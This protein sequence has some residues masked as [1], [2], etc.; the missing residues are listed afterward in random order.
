[1][2]PAARDSNPAV[3]ARGLTKLFGATPAL[4][5]ADL[6]VPT[7]TVCV[8]VGPNGAGK[9]TLLRLLA[10]ALRPTSGDARLHGAD[11][12]TQRAAVR[13]LVDFL[14]ASGGLYLDLTALE[15]LRFCAR[16]RSLH[17]DDAALGAALARAGLADVAGHRVRGFSSGMLR[18]LALA[19]LIVTRPPVALLDEPYAGLDEEGRELFD[20]LL[21]ELRGEGRT[22][23]LATH[24]RERALALADSVTWL[25]RGIVE[26]ERPA[27]LEARA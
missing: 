26:T 1:M 9:T 5:L 10:T 18:R 13:R 22:A 25:E 4:L 21:S 3:Q 16:M 17:A 27:P 23:I 19:R 20:C 11:V 15:N 24:E 12:V 2:T 14:P 7:G 8:L 6:D